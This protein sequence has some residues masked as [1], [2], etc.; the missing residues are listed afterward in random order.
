MDLTNFLQASPRSAAAA[1]VE[2]LS[3]GRLVAFKGFEYLIEACE[4][5]RQRSIQFHCEIIGDGPLREKLQQHIAD[6]RLDGWITQ[7][8]ALPQ[9]CVLEK[10]RDCDIFALASTTDDNGASDIFPTVILEA[11][12][13]AR[14]VVSTRLAGI[15][16]SV[17]DKETGLLVPAGESGLF[18]DAL[19]VLCRD[20][21]LRAR[22]GAAGRTRVE[23]HFQVETTVG[24]LLEKLGGNKA[25]VS[26]ASVSAASAGPQI[27]YLVDRWPDE[28][29][30][31]LDLE[32]SEMARRTGPVQVFVCEFQKDERLSSEQEK[33][34]LRLEFL[35]DA[36]AIEAEWQANR[37][38]VLALEDNRANESH[39]V[40]VDLFLRQAH[41]AVTLQ[42]MLKQRKICHVHATS[43]RALVC[44]VLLKKILGIS[45]S[46]SIEAKPTLSRDTIECALQHAVGGR[47]ADRKLAQQ[48]GAPFFFDRPGSNDPLVRGLRWLKPVSRID[49]TRPSS[50]WQEWIN[51]LNH[52]SAQ[53]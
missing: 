4:Q 32:L 34:A 39:R 20:P 30:S 46:A 13:S 16:E 51:R 35:P 38:L 3:V 21:D 53:A 12:A 22:F 33:L 43:S 27:G 8:G 29:V 42:R 9:D 17:V 23:Q 18:A 24:P 19:D 36:M 52:W 45:L 44:G 41:F 5:L 2:I 37:E 49:L 31:G 48:I 50:F 14:P 11:M 7:A 26:G 1:P 10:L 6:L 28:T 25:A 15:P 47:I 40:P